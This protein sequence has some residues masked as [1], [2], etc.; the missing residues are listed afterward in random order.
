MSE[1]LAWGSGMGK[2]LFGQTGTFDV[3]PFS[4]NGN[5][6]PDFNIIP[7]TSP[8]DCAVEDYIS[9]LVC[10]GSRFLSAFELASAPSDLLR[11]LVRSRPSG[12]SHRLD[13]PARLGVEF[14]VGYGTEQRVPEP[15]W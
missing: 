13:Q 14:L 15:G 9:L 10:C 2:S 8:S 11:D 7:R 3:S 6:K 4:V 1:D 12:P 5:L